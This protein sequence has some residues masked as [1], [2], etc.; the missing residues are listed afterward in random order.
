MSNCCSANEWMPYSGICSDCKE[1]AE[2][3]PDEKKNV[4]TEGCKCITQSDCKNEK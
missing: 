3:L 2:F 1:H 4:E